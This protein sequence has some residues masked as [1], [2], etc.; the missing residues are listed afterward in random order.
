VECYPSDIE[1]KLGFDVVRRS[2]EGRLQTEVGLEAARKETPSSDLD[3][4]KERLQLA[5]EWQDALESNQAP[6]MAGL[7]DLR[8]SLRSVAPA[9]SWLE[10]VAVLD[11]MASLRLA[12][13]VARAIGSHAER[14]PAIAQSC[15]DLFVDPDLEK[16]LGR[17]VDEQGGVKDDASPDLR[18]IRKQIR[19]QEGAMR[20]AAERALKTAREAGYG[21]GDAPTVRGGRAVIPI[22]IEG[23]RK[24]PGSIVDT[25]TSGK[26]AFLE[27]EECVDL[28]N[29][30]RLL[31][32]QERR[33]I[34]R[35][36][37]DVTD[38]I[39]AVAA[40]IL[41]NQ[42]ILANQD[43]YRAKAH[44]A[45][46]LEA[47]VPEISEGAVLRLDRGVNPALFLLRREAA[48]RGEVDRPVIPLNLT[49]EEPHRTLVISGPNA[50][51]KSVAMKTVGLFML[52]TAYGI[53]IPCREGSS[54]PLTDRLMVVLGDEQSLE[55]D[56]STFSS[57]LGHL[58]TV[59][60]K[61]GPN[62]LILI[63]EIGTGTDPAAGEAI[64]RA[65][66]EHLSQRGGLTIVTTH[67]GGL[68]AFAQDADGTVNGAMRFDPERLEPV[69]EFEL[70]MPGSSYALEIAERTEFPQP[71][72]EKARALFG[73]DRTQIEALILELSRTR[74]EFERRSSKLAERL[75]AA[76]E[77]RDR[78]Q[79]A[80]ERLDASRDAV[81]REAHEKAERVLK[82]ANRTVENTIREIKES[83]ADKARTRVA[84]EQ[85]DEYRA[86]LA[87]KRPKR[88]KR[89]SSTP[90]KEHADE[91]EPGDSVVM[92]EGSA[93]GEVM[94][95][96]GRRALVAFDL[97]QITVDKT[98]LQKVATGSKRK[99]STS[100]PVGPALEMQPRL[101][102]R[103]YR[104]HEAIPA[105]DKY[106]DDALR[107]GLQ[108]V[109]VLH[110]TGTGALREAV[111]DHLAD[112]AVVVSVE[113]APVDQGGAGVTY[114]FL[115]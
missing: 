4:V 88:P 68:K 48:A 99:R 26:T 57:H 104:V 101:D 66:L 19:N 27:P 92:D 75:A 51:G 24:L 87:S 33:E 44:L 23:R 114:V 113:E 45:R 6:G 21:A 63:D 12:R 47:V 50:G 105:L 89:R 20:R 111:R 108:R 81:L 82:E 84:R 18:R 8:D 60:E 62:T 7:P 67:F 10:P 65:V 97:T 38:D 43:V 74:E 115:S 94:E 36:L 102:I 29:E 95:L 98:R 61:S 70:G 39:R 32:S 55:N 31:E 83:Q 71:L 30:L 106:I 93:V 52:M 46:E 77:S 41:G 86:E 40:A 73:D 91:L 37:I 72:L 35:I 64:A 54:I 22:K 1:S 56:L 103:G 59:V 76:E 69:F 109:E 3:V 25:S 58:K 34:V 16:A 5:A 107:S 53:P 85:L 79:A 2:V 42:E 14:F 100:R 13:E 11:V 28:G 96:K 90:A 15:Q 112:M 78:H 49:L 110:G 80:R 9:G 17:V